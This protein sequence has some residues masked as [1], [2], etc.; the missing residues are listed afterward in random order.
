[1]V[2]IAANAIPAFPPSHPG[3]LLAEIIPPTGK[4]VAEIAD[5]LCLPRQNLDAIIAG[6]KPVSPEIAAKLGKFFGDG[7]A[8][9]LRMQAAHD[10]WRAEKG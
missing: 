4:N 5:L 3:E 8:V 10:A 7:A 1:M 9:W 6:R 2:E